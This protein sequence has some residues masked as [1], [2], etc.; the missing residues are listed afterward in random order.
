MNFHRKLP[1]P[2]D[3]KAEYPLKP[4][5]VAKKKERDAEIA[6]IFTGKDDRI[7]LIIGPCSADR[8]D[9]VLDYIHRLAVLQEK[10]KDRILLIPRI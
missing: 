3:V 6:N 7:V 2:K 4:E 9:A 8:E 1:I 5:Y 10:V